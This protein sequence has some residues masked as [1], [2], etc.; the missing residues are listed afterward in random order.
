MHLTL[1]QAIDAETELRKLIAL[2]E[3]CDWDGILAAS[4]QSLK[5][6]D[7]LGA[8]SA[9]AA[10]AAH[11]Y[12]MVASANTNAANPHLALQQ[13]QTSKTLLDGIAPTPH[14]FG[15]YDNV[16]LSLMKFN[17]YADA[18]LLYKQAFALSSTPMQTQKSMHCLGVCEECVGNRE[19]AI[20]CYAMAF[21]TATEMPDEHKQ[22]SSLMSAASCRFY[23]LEYDAAYA[24]FERVLQMASDPSHAQAV[25]AVRLGMGAVRWAQWRAVDRP[26]PQLL[27]DALGLMDDALNRSVEL[28][29]MSMRDVR[30]TLLR[31]AFANAD[32]ENETEALEYLHKMLELCLHDAATQCLQCMQ[33]HYKDDTMLTCG[34][35]RIARFCNE[36]CQRHASSKDGSRNGNHIVRHKELCPLLREWHKMQINR[37]TVDECVPLQREFLRGPAYGP[38]ARAHA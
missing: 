32:A 15:A 10:N 20:K 25:T 7:V 11:M 13:F 2:Y 4:Q 22:V 18:L 19:K 12:S 3:A 23:M 33:A 28:K 9:N 6:A 5:H 16:A 34:G 26:S 8:T 24:G 30:D 21:K 35:C 31:L 1:Q 38:G 14:K 17:R 36:D 29:N 37:M 27:G